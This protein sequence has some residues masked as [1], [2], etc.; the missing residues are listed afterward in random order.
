MAGLPGELRPPPWTVQRPLYA[1]G[2]AL[3]AGGWLVAP[4]TPGGERV[5]IELAARL[6][7]ENGSGRLSLGAGET[8]LA[9]VD[10]GAEW[11]V[12]TLGPFDWPAGE[13]LVI[14]GDE[15]LAEPVIV[16]RAELEWQ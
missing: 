9:T 1:G 16:D 15:A 6:D 10:V 2:W 8:R 14:R 7:A 4:V 3:P 12:Q 5:T 11:A 13:R